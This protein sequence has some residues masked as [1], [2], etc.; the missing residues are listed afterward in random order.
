MY[1]KCTTNS[2]AGL[3]EPQHGLY[4]SPGTEFDVTVGESYPVYGMAMYKRGLIVLLKD[5]TGKP[6]W[7][8]VELFEV[9]DGQLPAGWKFATRDD[10]ELGMQAIFGYPELV[11]DEGHKDAL[12]ERDSAALL[13]F[14]QQ[15][16][17]RD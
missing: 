14:E 8:P 10:G 11:D 16:A 6:N 7:H 15:V 1:V 17:N 3:G 5:D 4:F 9:T 2:A 12:L 13:T